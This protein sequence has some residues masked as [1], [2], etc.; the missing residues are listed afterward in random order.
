LHQVSFE[1]ANPLHIFRHFKIFTGLCKVRFISKILSR[2]GYVTRRISS[3]QGCSEYLLCFAST[4]MHFTI[5]LLVLCVLLSWLTSSVAL[6][7]CRCSPDQIRGTIRQGSILRV[8]Q[9][10][11]PVTLYNTPVTCFVSSVVT[12]QFPL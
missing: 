6:G 2:V 8:W 11:A 9:S 4:I 7:L 3:R 10:V 1:T 5:I 12:Q